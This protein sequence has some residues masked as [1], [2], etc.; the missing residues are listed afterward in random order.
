M[1]S[2]GIQAFELLGLSVQKE[3]YTAAQ[4]AVFVQNKHST[5]LIQ[6][7]MFVCFREPFERLLSSI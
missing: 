7:A 3:I 1:V 5:F 6:M 2:D 4:M